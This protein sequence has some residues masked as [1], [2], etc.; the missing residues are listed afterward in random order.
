MVACRQLGVGSMPDR[1]LL[2]SVFA[3]HL[4]AAL[5]VVHL[6]PILGG[7]YG[8][9]GQLLPL[10]RLNP[11]LLA[12]REHVELREAIDRSVREEADWHARTNQHERDLQGLQTL[13]D[14]RGLT[15]EPSD[16]EPPYGSLRTL[17]PH[18]RELLGEPTNLWWPETG[19]TATTD[20]DF[21]QGTRI[22]LLVG[23]D[24]TAPL[25]ATQWLELLDG[26]LAAPRF[27]QFELAGGGVTSWLI[28]TYDTDYE[29]AIASRISDATDAALL[30]KLIVIPGRDGRTLRLVGLTLDRLAALSDET[31]GWL[32]VV[33]VLVQDGHTDEVRAYSKQTSLRRHARVSLLN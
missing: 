6:Q 20:G 11:A 10:S 23:A 30:G 13:L 19:L 24:V 12:G 33:G 8:P 9:A 5:A 7:P 21:D 31:A 22:M 25:E 27:G 28:E 16:L 1:D 29:E 2:A 3:R 15:L 14:E 4:E 18:H 26:H 17:A 32:N